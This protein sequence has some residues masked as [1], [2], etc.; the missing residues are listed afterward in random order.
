M[1]LS[2]NHHSNYVCESGNAPLFGQLIAQ[3]SRSFLGFSH[4]VTGGGLE[5][6]KFFKFTMYV[7]ILNR[8]LL[9][10]ATQANTTGLSA[11]GLL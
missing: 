4:S 9:V 10:F 6:T 1:A 8:N 5:R 11:C 2:A 3:N 7:K